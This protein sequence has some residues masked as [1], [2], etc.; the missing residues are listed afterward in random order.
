[1]ETILHHLGDTQH[2]HK[3][4]IPTYLLLEDSL[5]LPHINVVHTGGGA[6]LSPFDKT[7]LTA[8]LTNINMKVREEGFI[9]TMLF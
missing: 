3:Q 8:P 5:V 7:P 4:S 1:M 2:L 9:Q 6:E